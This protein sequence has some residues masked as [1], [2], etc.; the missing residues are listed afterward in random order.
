MSNSCTKD[1]LLLATFQNMHS[2][3]LNT[4]NLIKQIVMVVSTLLVG[5]SLIV[6]ICYKCTSDQAYKKHTDYGNNSDVEK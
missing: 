6:S 5:L 1:E 3:V 2:Y 4:R